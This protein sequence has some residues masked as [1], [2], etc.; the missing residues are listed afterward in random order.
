MPSKMATAYLCDTHTISYAPS[1]TVFALCQEKPPSHM[2]A[3]LVMGIP[4]DRAP[5][6]LDEVQSVAAIL[7]S[8]DLFLGTQATTEVLK[9]KGGQ[10]ALLHIAT[11]GTY[12]QD[13]PMFS[14]IRLG[15]GYLNLYD[16]YQMRLSARHVTLSGCATGMNFVAAGDELLG[17]QRGLFCA[18]AASL[19]LSL[20]DVHDSS[21]SQLMQSFYKGFMETGNMAIA[22]QSAMKQL[23]EQNPHPYFWAPFVLVGQLTENKRLN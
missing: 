21:T 2:S 7:P 14:G 23:R 13:N 18:G 3:S 12:R 22:L 6:I 20:W 5:Q 9:T 1:A 15:D 8:A 16:L 4:D 19:L 11:H 17:L 10:S